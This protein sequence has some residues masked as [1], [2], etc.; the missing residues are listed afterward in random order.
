MGHIRHKFRTSGSHFKEELLQL[1]CSL[2][3][4][5]IALLLHQKCLYLGDSWVFL[6]PIDIISDPF[7]SLSNSSMLYSMG[8]SR[9]TSS[10]GW[11]MSGC[12]IVHASWSNNI[13]FKINSC[14]SGT[15]ALFST[16]S[17]VVGCCEVLGILSAVGWCT[18]FVGCHGGSILSFCGS[19]SERQF[20]LKTLCL[21]PFLQ[22]F[23]LWIA[24]PW[25]LVM[26]QIAWVGAPL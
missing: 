20:Q 5:A 11:A 1:L 24:L 26:P 23:L 21:Y 16:W 6:K 4:S 9:I 18:Q 2:I 15:L 10:P 17:N 22:Y 3:F 19:Q 13:I 7:I 8:F 14:R 12:P 25:D